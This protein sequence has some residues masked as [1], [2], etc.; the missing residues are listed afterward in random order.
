MNILIIVAVA[1]CSVLAGVGIGYVWKR[2]SGYE[3]GFTE[4]LEQ[5]KGEAAKEG[6]NL[7]LE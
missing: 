7:A 5:G 6:H 2:N 1:I 4:G 3:D